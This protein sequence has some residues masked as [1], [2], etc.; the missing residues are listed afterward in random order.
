MSHFITLKL[1]REKAPL[2]YPLLRR[3]FRIRVEAG[4]PLRTVLT[5]DLGISG[6][7]ALHRIQTVL[8]DGS[9]VDDLDAAL[10]SGSSTLALSAAMPGLLGATL[11]RSGVYAGLRSSITHDLNSSGIGE[12]TQDLRVKLYNVLAEEWGWHFLSRGLRVEAGEFASVAAQRLSDL[13]RAL[14]EIWIDD[15]LVSARALLDWLEQRPAGEP[16]QLQVVRE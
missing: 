12:G 7:E 1:D 14:R 3:G 11:R 2:L 8:L 5:R 6:E 9:P 4:T 13:E 10:P 16:I 15:T